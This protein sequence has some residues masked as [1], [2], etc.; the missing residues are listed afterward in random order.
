MSESWKNP[1]I[2]FISLCSLILVSCTAG[3]SK[4]M[5]FQDVKTKYSISSVGKSNKDF[6]DALDIW[7]AKSFGDWQKVKQTANEERGIFIFRYRDQY[8]VGMSTKCGILVS[9]EVKRESEGFLEVNFS[10]IRHHLS[11]C[12]WINE[13]GVKQLNANFAKTVESIQKAIADI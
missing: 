11:D 2:L 12:T 13:P 3:S 10:N 4:Q 6:I 8:S 1:K 7:G 5:S 9:V